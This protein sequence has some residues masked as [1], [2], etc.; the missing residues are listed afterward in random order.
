VS[1]KTD[2]AGALVKRLLA[3]ATV[4]GAV[5]T[6]VHW[7]VAPP[8]SPVPYVL[9]RQLSSEEHYHFLGSSELM[10]DRW[11]VEIYSLTPATV[12][13][14]YRAIRASLSGFTGDLSDGAAW[15]PVDVQRLH[16]INMTDSHETV[17]DGGN[18]FVLRRTMD[19]EIDITAP[20][21]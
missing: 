5:G 11:T 6:K 1:T 15:G 2:I 13:T 3:N 20:L 8:N 17:N 4:A 16:L 18:V 12:N 7:M 10:Q 14:L 9:V 21:T 19:F